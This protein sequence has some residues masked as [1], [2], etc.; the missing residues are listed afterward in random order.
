MP[1]YRNNTDYTINYENKGKLY[2]FPPHKE[3][4]AKFWVPYQELGLELVSADY[5]PVPDSIL[6]S[7]TFRFDYD[8]ERRF[9]FERCSKYHLNLELWEGR[10]KLYTGSSRVGAEINT[11]YDV[12][13]DWEKAPYIRVVGLDGKNIVRIHVEVVDE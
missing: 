9:N 5:P 7:G 3:Y 10:I 4:P 12:V 11:N 1:T 6:L 2:S 8:I 13:L